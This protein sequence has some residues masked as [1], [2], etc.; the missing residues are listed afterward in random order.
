MPKINEK[1]VKSIIE[2]TDHLYGENSDGDIKRFPGSNFTNNL[3]DQWYGFEMTIGQS[4]SVVTAIGHTDLKTSKPVHAAMYPAVV[5]EDG[6]I[7]QILDKGRI[8]KQADGSP[9]TIDGTL[10]DVMLIIPEYYRK[11]EITDTKVRVMVSPYAIPGFTKIKQKGYGIYKAD[12]DGSDKLRSR[13]GVTPLTSTT[14]ANFRTY[15]DNKNDAGYDVTWHQKDYEISADLYWLFVMDELNLSAQAAI[16]DGATN[17]SSTDWS[18]YNSYNPVWDNGEGD[19]EDVWTGQIAVA[20]ANF[21]GGS[22][23]LNTNIAVLYGIRDVFGHLWEW[24]DGLNL[25]NSTA[26][27]ARAFACANP[28]NFADDTDTNY[29]LIAQLAESDGYISKL[30][31]GT[32]LPS[33]VSGGSTNHCGDYHYSYFNNDPDSGWRVA[34]FGGNL[35]DGSTAGLL[36]SAF[37]ISSGFVVAHLGAR[38]CLQWNE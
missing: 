10:G 3:F 19:D 25:H 18:N 30:I 14:R 35:N 11:I 15:A 36:C 21:V 34:R 24:V 20:V 37:N 23:D 8:D 13:S 31:W 5:A 38:L 1:P 9:S 7:E 12:K 16:G 28:D 29:S 4:S 33:E 26:N 6:T 32:I 22:S 27:G 2:D 17:A